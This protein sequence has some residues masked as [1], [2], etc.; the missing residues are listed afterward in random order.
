MK[1]LNKH[2]PSD[3]IIVPASNREPGMMRRIHKD[4][5]I[6]EKCDFQNC[7]HSDNQIHDVCQQEEKI[8]SLACSSSSVNIQTQAKRA[9]GE[10]SIPTGSVHSMSQ[11]PFNQA[12]KR[13]A[14]DTYRISHDDKVCHGD[15]SVSAE[16]SD[17]SEISRQYTTSMDD[18]QVSRQKSLKLFGIEFSQETKRPSDEQQNVS[19]DMK[20]KDFFHK[21]ESVIKSG[22]EDKEEEEACKEIQ[23]KGISPKFECNFCL[24]NFPTSQA[25]G[26][27]QNAHKRERQQAKRLNMLQPADLDHIIRPSLM[28]LAEYNEVYY[29]LP[30]H[31]QNLRLS[32]FPLIAPHA[33]NI[34]GANPLLNPNYP[35]HKLV[36]Y[37]SAGGH[38]G[39][40]APWNRPRHPYS[41]FSSMAGSS[42]LSLQKNNINWALQPETMGSNPTSPL[43]WRTKP[44]V[45]QHS[46]SSSIPASPLFE[47]KCCGHAEAGLITSAKIMGS[48]SVDDNNFITD[49]S[50][51]LCLDLHLNMGSRSN[52]STNKG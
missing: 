22:F 6:S 43:L 16:Q 10:Q 12:K 34:N 27:H 48:S 19:E 39:M 23:R 45:Q 3:S 28:F 2:C 17:T 46:H 30:K 21:E 7:N 24:R 36:A 13:A 33:C 37:A 32:G 44:P 1:I 52:I 5:G 35:N 42:S 40:N 20:T 41:R 4:V 8:R 11:E 15:G 25:L 49:I 38:M 14:T 47:R 29:G 18:L 50:G 51:D 26:G 9:M 31:E